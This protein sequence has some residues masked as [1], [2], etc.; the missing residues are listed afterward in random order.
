MNP[1][2]KPV[3]DLIKDPNHWT[4]GVLG[5]DKDDN[6]ISVE[7]AYKFCLVGAMYKAYPLVGDS[8]QEIYNLMNEYDGS[9]S[10]F[11]DNH[12]HAEVLAFLESL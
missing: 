2:I 11:N 1:L 8:I 12:T 9:A 4:Q 7:K 6:P 5:R 3:Y 10:V